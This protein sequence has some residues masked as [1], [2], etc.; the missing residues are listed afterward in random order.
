[1]NGV[2]DKSAISDDDIP[3]SLQYFF[4]CFGLKLPHFS[5]SN[6]VIPAIWGEAMDVP[7]YT[8]DKPSDKT[9]IILLPA[10]KIST[11][12]PLSEESLII[13]SLGFTAVKSKTPVYSG[14]LKGFSESQ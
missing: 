6:A 11:P 14:G 13:S 10:A 12:G 3:Y 5:N 9:L 8:P 2:K 4:N 1:M 7:E